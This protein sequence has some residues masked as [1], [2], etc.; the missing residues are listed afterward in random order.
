M[1]KILNIGRTVCAILFVISIALM[2]VG[3][4]DKWVCIPGLVIIAVIGAVF[5]VLSSRLMSWKER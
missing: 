1:K 4:V 3:E 2:A 5:F